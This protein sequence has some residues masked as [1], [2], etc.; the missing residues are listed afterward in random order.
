VAKVVY[1]SGVGLREASYSKSSIKSLPYRFIDDE[2][3]AVLLAGKNTGKKIS[4][5][6]EMSSEDRDEL[7]NKL[8]KQDVKIKK[9]ID[10]LCCK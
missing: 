4:E 9:I 8:Y 1:N 2:A 5:I 6:W 10:S 7:F 3:D